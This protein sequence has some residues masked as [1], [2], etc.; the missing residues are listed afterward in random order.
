M[1]KLTL[2]ILSAA[3][4][5]SVL[6]CKKEQV[7]TSGANEETVQTDLRQ[8]ETEGFISRDC[9]RVII[10]QPADSTSSIADIDKQART[11]AFL[12]LKRYITSSGK[13]LGQN[14][15]AGI[16]NIIQENGKLTPY[17]D[18]ARTIYVLEISKSGCK[19]YVDTLGK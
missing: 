15:D 13:T 7:K 1:K 10:V 6:A 18:A 9:F 3:C 16:L 8:F 4:A 2:I 17:K 14:A 19:S 5:V 12:S 11:K